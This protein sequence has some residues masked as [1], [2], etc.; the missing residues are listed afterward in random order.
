MKLSRSR[1]D[2]FIKCP[3]CFYLKEKF[4]INP[5]STPK[6]TIN[7]RVDALLKIEF[8]EL[9]KQ[10]KPHSIFKEYNLNFVPYN[11]LDE[12]TLKKYRHNNSGVRAKS[13]KT[14]I[15][16]FG[17]IDDL[18]FNKDTKQVV[19]LD[20]KATSSKNLEDYTKSDKHYHKSY[21][22]QLDFYAYLLKLNKFPVQDTAYW[23]ICNAANED[24]KTFDKKIIFKTTLLPYKLKTD[25][26]EDSLVAL[27]ACLDSEK[28]PNSGSDCDNCRWYDEKKNII[29][30]L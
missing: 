20:C 14:G 2:N 25:Y 16:I 3:K 6:F 21:Q 9:R 13:V 30:K 29:M 12:D 22:R 7:S 1:W 28:I 5:P 15:E 18:W 27:K 19:V 26:I 8:D 23:L 11:D 24:Q 10:E 4:N 17:A